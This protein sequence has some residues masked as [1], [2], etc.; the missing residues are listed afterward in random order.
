L[1]HRPRKRFGQHFLH[2]PRVIHDIVSAISPEPGDTLV[3]IG[4]GRGAITVPLLE[5]TERM[6]VVELDRDLVPALQARCANLGRLE[7][8]QADALR[9]DFG[10]LSPGPGRLRVVGNLPYN[11][12]TPLLFHLTGF[13]GLIRDIH[14][15]LQ[16]EVV[17]RITAEP[18]GK[19]WGRLS[20]MLRYRFWARR[21]FQVGP[22]AFRPPPKV[23]ST[24]LRLEPY[25]AP[26]VAVEDEP[27]FAQLVNRAF[28]QRRKTIRK[29]LG[30]L[31][32]EAGISAVGVDP[33]LRAE[34]LDLKAFAD[35]ANASL[36]RDTAA[37]PGRS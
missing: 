33:G 25:E 7:V 13:A 1:I 36:H 20:V 3:E 37:I 16:R 12:S 9:F 29:S 2:D 31:L 18:G 19:T 24:F 23:E 6:D 21:L 4:P 26:P 11:I 32:D 14:F 10:A 35:L 34:V 28:S 8:H 17:E 30:G 5:R 22:G 27:R 15:L